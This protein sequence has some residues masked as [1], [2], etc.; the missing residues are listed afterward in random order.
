ML[1]MTPKE[2]ARAGETAYGLAVEEARS[3]GG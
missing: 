3:V 1:L 2:E